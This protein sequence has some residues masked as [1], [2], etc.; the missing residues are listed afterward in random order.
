MLLIYEKNK[1]Q[2]HATSQTNFEF[3]ALNEKSQTQ[4]RE[5]SPADS[6]C[7]A[8]TEFQAPPPVPHKT[9]YSGTNK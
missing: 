9:R 4:F 5:W 7:L 2:I 8:S 6:Q 1:I 3:I